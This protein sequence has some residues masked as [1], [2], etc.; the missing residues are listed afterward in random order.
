ML[1][2]AVLMGCRAKPEAQSGGDG[3]RHEAQ[4]LAL[5]AWTTD[6]L[7]A[8]SGDT[9][10]WKSIEISSPAQMIVELRADEADA[11]FVVGAYDRYGAPLG[12]VE[13]RA[14]VPVASFGFNAATVGTHFIMVRA[15]GGPPSS[16]TIRVRS[17]DSIEGGTT[18]RPDF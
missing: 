4:P 12:K 1:S 15:T 2:V 14:E 16:Y 11:E 6:D 5:E 10:D 7:A 18:I 9:T 17:G 8:G 13:R 3:Y